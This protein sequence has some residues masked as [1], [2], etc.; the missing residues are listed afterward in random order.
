MTKLL[1][2]YDTVVSF[3]YQLDAAGPSGFKN[4]LLKKREKEC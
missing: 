2:V 4:A 3:F 1:I